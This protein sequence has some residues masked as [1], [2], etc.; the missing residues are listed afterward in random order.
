MIA[1]LY[2]MKEKCIKS[3]K[4]Y[5]HEH[6]L[7]FTTCI[8]LVIKLFIFKS[9][10]KGFSSNET[11]IKLYNENSAMLRTETKNHSVLPSKM[12]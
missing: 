3:T 8:R 12:Y 9:E 5:I 6:M 11:G 2:K 1:T 10:G 7:F 4:Y